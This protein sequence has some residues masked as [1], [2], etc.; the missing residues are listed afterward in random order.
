MKKALAV[1]GILGLLA[2][3]A[4]AQAP[5]QLNEGSLLE[6]DS[7]NQLYRFKWWGAS[8]KTYF[9]QH[10]DDLKIWNWVPMVEPG[11]DSIKEWGFTS[12][13]TK[14]FARLQY[15][16]GPTTDPAGDDFDRDGVPNLFEVQQGLSPFKSDTDGDGMTDGY[17]ISNYLNP[18]SDDSY[19]NLDGD[20]YSNITEFLQD[21]NPQI[22]EVE[23]SEVGLLVFTLME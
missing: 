3:S 13:G 8:G 1:F 16:T 20:A 5:G 9:I 22:P 18:L 2:V 15:W 4:V 7:A 19:L 21:T 12:T 14:F 10:S 23:G 11:N 6:V 17:E